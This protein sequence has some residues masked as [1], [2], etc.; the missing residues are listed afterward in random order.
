M[1]QFFRGV[2]ATLVI[3]LILLLLVL[4]YFGFIPGLSK[5]M[6]S[7]KPRDL[8]IRYTPADQQAAYVKNGVEAVPQ[9]PTGDVTNSVR[10]EGKKEVT[11]AMSSTE[12]TALVNGNKWQYQP[13]TD[14]QIRINP[15]GTGE[16]TGVLHVDLVLPFVSLTH[17]TDQ[18]RD[19]M[20]KYHIGGNPPFYLKG[21]VSVVNNRV[22]LQP[23]RVEIGRMAIPMG[24][25]T[26]NLGTLEGFAEARIKAVPNLNVESLSHTDG[27]VNFRGTM[28]TKE[29]KAETGLPVELPMP[30]PSMT[31]ISA[32][33]TSMPS[34]APETEKV[35]DTYNIAG[36]IN[37]PT[38][39]AT[40]TLKAPKTIYLIQD[41]HWNSAN[42]KAPGTIGLKDAGGKVYGPWAPETAPGQG[43]VPNAYWTVYP[44]VELPAGTYTIV[45]SDPASWAQ[46]S[47]TNGVGMSQVLVVK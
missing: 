37:N 25:L 22:T 1:K 43:G 29:Y 8:R 44:N 15:D 45:D 18:V 41:Y 46:N 38:K 2:I 31:N 16:A 5:V 3:L 10:Y 13:V 34:P 42:G 39:P 14:V 26:A 6:G 4:G 32:T 7:G 36:V 47:G 19:A 27:K 23:V 40:F 21:R 30:S 20:A 12:I 24:L 35:F 33:A 28:P 11:F 17:T 9:P